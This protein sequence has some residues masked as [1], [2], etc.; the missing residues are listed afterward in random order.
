[1]ATAI[2]QGAHT[3]ELMRLLGGD[4]LLLLVP[5]QPG[6][7]GSGGAEKPVDGGGVTKGGG[8]DGLGGGGDGGRGGG[9]RPGLGGGCGGRG[10]LGLGGGGGT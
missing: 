3:V 4:P 1:M 5:F 7:A 9:G 10:G 6:V 2:S 8:T